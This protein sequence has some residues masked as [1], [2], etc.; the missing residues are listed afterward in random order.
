LLCLGFWCFAGVLL[1]F[2]FLFF[3]QPCCLPLLALFCCCVLCLLCTL[4]GSQNI[5]YVYVSVYNI[6]HL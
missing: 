1:R 4:F 6:I 5:S 2:I 3:G